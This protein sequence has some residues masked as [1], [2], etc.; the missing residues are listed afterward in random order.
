MAAAV[1][2]VAGARYPWGWWECSMALTTVKAGSKSSIMTTYVINLSI[3]PNKPIP[4][5]HIYHIGLG[6]EWQVC[7]K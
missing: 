2:A 3:D 7:L 6:N 1:E 4:I 5:K